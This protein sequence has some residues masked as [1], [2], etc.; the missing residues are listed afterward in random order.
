MRQGRLQR[1]VA[2]VA[3]LGIHALA[4]FAFL[5][6]GRDK[7]PPTALASREAAA[8][9][10]PRTGA[11]AAQTS[12]A[13]PEQ[14]GRAIDWASE[15]AA[16]AKNHADVGRPEFFGRPAPE[17]RKPCKVKDRIW[18]YEGNGPE[19]PPGAVAVGKHCVFSGIMLT[20]TSKLGTVEMDTEELLRDLR[21][22][23]GPSV[24]HPDQCE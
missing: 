24:P 5:S 23:G 10:V 6:G 8:Q 12:V 20:C 3:A 2:G 11:I 4:V 18:F 15:A 21:E 1:I 16:V 13:A 17:P 22:N 9:R 7:S 19:L 14:S